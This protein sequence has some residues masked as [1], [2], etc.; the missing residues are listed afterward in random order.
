M[1]IRRNVALTTERH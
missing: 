1:N